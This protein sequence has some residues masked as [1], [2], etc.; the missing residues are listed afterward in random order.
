MRYRKSN[1]YETGFWYADNFLNAFLKIKNFSG[2]NILDIGTGHGGVLKYFSSLDAN[3]YGIDISEKNLDRAIQNN[4]KNVFFAKLNICDKKICE[5]LPLMDVIIL[6]DVIEH[7]AQ[8]ISALK[9]INL[10]L[11]NSGKLFLS[12]PPKFSPFAGHQQNIKKKFFR[13]PFIHL[14]PKVYL[15]GSTKFVWTQK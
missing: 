2:L 4:N 5:N 14:F 6:R 12:F 7:I 11:K 15:F 9:N 10:L 8:K 13:L 3:C 1:F